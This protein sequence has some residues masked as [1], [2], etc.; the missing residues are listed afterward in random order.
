MNQDRHLAHFVDVLQ[1]FRRALH[2]LT[3]EVDVDRLPVG[4]DEIEH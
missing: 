1:I 2:R 3:E 4:A